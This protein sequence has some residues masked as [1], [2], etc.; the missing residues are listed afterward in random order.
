[1]THNRVCRSL[2]SIYE[3]KVIQVP[4]DEALLEAVNGRAKSRHST[5]SAVIREACTDYLSRL[6]QEALDRK[7][8]EGYR[9]KPESP[10]VG[11]LGEKMAREVWPEENW[12]KAW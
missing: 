3:M 7:Y 6:E 12:D 9:R 1:M 2:R 4:M 5:R 8:V 10:L 11:K